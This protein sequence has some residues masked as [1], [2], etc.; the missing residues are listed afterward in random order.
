MFVLVVG[1]QFS[2]LLIEYGLFSIGL[3]LD[4]DVFSGSHGH[5]AGHQTRD[6]GNQYAVMR[7]MRGG[8][9]NEKAECRHKGLPVRFSRCI[10]LPVLWRLYVARPKKERLLPISLHK[11]GGNENG[12]VGPYLTLEERYLTST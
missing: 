8:N 10:S 4:G 6:S 2:S 9:S 7:S 11:D 12:V 3:R 5:R 1:F